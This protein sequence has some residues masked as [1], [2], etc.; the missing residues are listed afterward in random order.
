MTTTVSAPRQTAKRSLLLVLIAAL[1]IG[2]FV[3]KDVFAASRTTTTKSN[4]PFYSSC[5]IK[6]LDMYAKDTFQI[7]YEKGKQVVTVK[8]SQSC[9]NLGTQMFEK[10]GIK[11]VSKANGTWTYQSTWYLNLSVLPTC[12]KG[13]ANYAYPGLGKLVNLGRIGTMTTTYTVDKYGNLKVTAK[14]G[15]LQVPSSLTATAKKVGKLFNIKF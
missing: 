7:T 8:T 2:L 11:L 9:K 13:L 3:P 10:G 6:Q 4:T 14:K 1:L 5:L 15:K 12:M